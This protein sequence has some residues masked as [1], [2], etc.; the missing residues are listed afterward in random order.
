MFLLQKYQLICLPFQEEKEGN[1]YLTSID[2]MCLFLDENGYAA[3]MERGTVNKNFKEKENPKTI[4]VLQN[5]MLFQSNGAQLLKNV[6]P[7]MIASAEEKGYWFIYSDARKINN[8]D[9]DTESS[10][11]NSIAIAFLLDNIS[12][13][14]SDRGNRS[15]F[16]E[17]DAKELKNEFARCELGDGYY[18]DIESDELKKIKIIK[19]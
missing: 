1:F 13:F 9:R 8:N 15:V 2:Q 4:F 11:N 7:K 19:V 10:L 5:K 12:E 14:V 3:K 16:G 17:M 6:F 18:F